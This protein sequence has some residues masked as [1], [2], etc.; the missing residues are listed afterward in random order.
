LA[1]EEDCQVDLEFEAGRAE[2]RRQAQEWAGLDQNPEAELF[3]FVGRWS[4]QKGVSGN[5]PSLGFDCVRVV[6]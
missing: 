3:V 2:L 5:C 4:T 6:V 1:K